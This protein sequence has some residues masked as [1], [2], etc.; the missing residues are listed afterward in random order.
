MNKKP[1]GEFW[2]AMKEIAEQAR[3]APEWSKAGINL[4]PRNFD[5]FRKETS[6]ANAQTS[7][8]VSADGKK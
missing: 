1:S 2:I 8:P 7:E 5:T 4:N 3:Q 6:T